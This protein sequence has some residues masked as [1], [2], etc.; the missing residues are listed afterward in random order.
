MAVT[1]QTYSLSATWTASGL[2]NTFRSA[3]I[4]AGLMT[5]WHDS[6]L[7]G[8]IENRILKVIHDAGTYG[9]TYYWF[10]FTTTGW[11]F[12][13]ANDWN[14]STHVPQGTLYLDY[15]ATTTNAVTNHYAFTGLVATT[16]LT[17]TR[18]GS[19]INSDVQWFRIANG[20]VGWSF[21]I[22]RPGW[23]ASNTVLDF[24]RASYNGFISVDTGAG[25]GSLNALMGFYTVCALRRNL[26]SSLVGTSS[27]NVAY[28][29]KVLLMRYNACGSSANST[30]TYAAAF[31]GFW[32]PAMLNTVNT[33]MANNWVP[34]ITG[35]QPAMWLPAMPADFAIA[36][37]VSNNTQVRG[38][39][40][41]VSAGVS[42]WEILETITS[43]TV[44]M[45][46]LARII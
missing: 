42:E 19:G 26:W 29:Q 23:D 45:M 10:M 2:A 39:T 9:T 17:I 43:T 34:M 44:R 5:E 14:V 1:K 28:N 41:V 33:S 22:T 32:L 4:D 30:N 40:Y 7:S 16:A 21:T 6:F 11:Y 38:D 24:S 18:Y 35:L 37:D 46:F 36:T 20:S 15:F 12:H 27:S 3:F 8:S 31:T 13:I 25:V